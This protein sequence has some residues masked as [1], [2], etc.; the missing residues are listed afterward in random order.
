MSHSLRLCRKWL[1]NSGSASDPG[2]ASGSM[3]QPDGADSSW[4]TGERAPP[5]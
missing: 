4:R 3:S 1:C 5:P 2:L